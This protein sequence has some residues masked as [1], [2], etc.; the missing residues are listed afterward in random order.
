MFGRLHRTAR[1]IATTT[2]AHSHFAGASVAR[3][4]AIHARIGGV[5]PDDP[6]H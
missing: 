1:F 6:R 3:V 2:Y 4:R 5:L